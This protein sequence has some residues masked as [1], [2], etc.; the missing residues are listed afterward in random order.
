MSRTLKLSFHAG[1]NGID[2]PMR[3]PNRFAAAAVGR[4]ANLLP[5]MLVECLGSDVRVL[6]AGI[7]RPVQNDRHRPEVAEP[8]IFTFELGNHIISFVCLEGCQKRRDLA[9]DLRRRFDF[10]L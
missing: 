9:R 7:H 4:S 2:L 8:A 10:Q 6:D 1:R 5:D 3:L